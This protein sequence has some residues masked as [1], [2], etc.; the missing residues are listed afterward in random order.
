[1]LGI[2]PRPKSLENGA[3]L[4][5]T[6]LFTLFIVTMAAF[7]DGF[8]QLEQPVTVS[9]SLDGRLAVIELLTL[10]DGIDQVSSYM[11]PAGG[12]FDIRYFIIA[13]VSVGL[14]IAPWIVARCERSGCKR[15]SFKANQSFD[16][17]MP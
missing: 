13:L 14:Q 9:Y 6:E 4:L 2:K 1:M 7:I 3:F 17:K 16:L 11:R 15:D 8:L 12:S 5:K 10:G